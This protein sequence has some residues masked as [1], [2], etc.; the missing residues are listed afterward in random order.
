MTSFS[1]KGKLKIIFLHGLLVTWN[2]KYSAPITSTYMPNYWKTFPTYW[3]AI[4]SRFLKEDYTVSVPVKLFYLGGKFV[5]QGLISFSLPLSTVDV[6]VFVCLH[7]LVSLFCLPVQVLVGSITD[8]DWLHPYM[9]LLHWL[10]WVCQSLAWC[11]QTWILIFFG[12]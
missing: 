2:I 10:Y 1:K 3:V 11:L 12:D 4:P 9:F 6:C 5:L 8:S 7:V